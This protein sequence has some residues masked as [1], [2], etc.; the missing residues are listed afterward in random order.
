MVC[1][2]QLGVSVGAYRAGLEFT[3]RAFCIGLAYLSDCF[4]KIKSH[5]L[6]HMTNAP[7]RR[8]AEDRNFHDRPHGIT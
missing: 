5:L 8:F 6:G 7:N 3:L 2:E 1:L 4:M